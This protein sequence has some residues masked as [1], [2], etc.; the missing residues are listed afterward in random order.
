LTDEN[1]KNDGSDDDAFKVE[2]PDDLLDEAVSA[3]ERRVGDK[4]ADPALESTIPDEP[5]AEGEEST[6]GMGIEESVEIPMS[7]EAEGSNE[8]AADLEAMSVDDLMAGG[9]LPDKVVTELNESRQK[10]REAKA[11]AEQARE[12]TNALMAEADSFR[13]RVTREKNE[14]LKFANEPLLKEVLPVLDNLERALAHAEQSDI[15]AT[16]IRQGVEITV[17]QFHNILAKIGVTKVPSDRGVPFD[18]RMHE[19][20]QHMETSDVPPGSVAMALQSGWILHDRLLRPAMVAVAKAVEEPAVADPT[21]EMGLADSPTQPEG[22]GDIA[23]TNDEILSRIRRAG[24]A[25]RAARQEKRE[26]RDEARRERGEPTAEDRLFRMRD[27][28]A[29]AREARE[30]E[31]QEEKLEKIR[32]A[33]AAKRGEGAQASE[34]A[35]LWVAPPAKPAPPAP[36]S[37]P[38]AFRLIPADPAATKFAP[39]VIPPPVRVEVPDDEP[40]V[41]VWS[42]AAAEPSA[43][44]A[45]ARAPAE[46][47]K[48]AAPA[49]PRPAAAPAAPAA[50]GA[51]AP[52][53]EDDDLSDWES[54]VDAIRTDTESGRRRG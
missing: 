27:A 6:D 37:P 36:P 40:A 12:R 8:V 22:D 14:A 3:V 25:V 39:P 34:P 9:Y 20:V 54:S 33:G 24:E 46:A 26:E 10:T 31:H 23:S 44:A 38:I 16:G 13:K 29:R 11:Q 18:P 15:A 32:A 7:T 1:P 51:P 5:I 35:E 17:R 45:P 43:A 49:A 19:A 53:F 28:A 2:I 52:S 47:P 30:A 4:K 21:E 50:P 48:A 42:P 41:A